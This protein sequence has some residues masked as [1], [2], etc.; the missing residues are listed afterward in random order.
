MPLS[1]SL[2]NKPSKDDKIR[3]LGNMS[4]YRVETTSEGECMYSSFIY[5]LFLKQVG[6]WNK[7]PGWIPTEIKTG[8][9]CNYMGNLR[10]V[11]ANYICQ[12]QDK[13]LK[14]FEPKTLLESVKR[15]TG[16]SWGEDTEL[17][18]LGIMFGVCIVI[19]KGEQVGDLSTM[20]DTMEIY[21]KSAPLL[22]PFT[23]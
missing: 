23:R 16:K 21:D 10:N 7:I 2:E 17:K 15:I 20:K 18:I 12:N 14:L 3:E 9:K 1:K 22:R 19:F 6:N 4:L 13:L 5:S 8:S 11:L